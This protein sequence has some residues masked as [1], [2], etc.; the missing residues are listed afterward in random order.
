[1]YG[2]L[3]IFCCLFSLS[4]GAQN[5]YKS[6]VKGVHGDSINKVDMNDRKQGKWVER[7]PALR[8]NPGY[9]AEGYYLDDLKVGTW[10]TYNLMGDKI[11]EE[12]FRY[13]NK[14]GRCRYFT[15]AGLVRE[16]NW[17][18]PRKLDKQQLDTILVQ[19]PGEPNVY[20]RVV[21][22]MEGQSLKHGTW[23]YFDPVYGR[24]IAE[25]TYVLDVLQEGTGSPAARRDTAVKKQVMPK[26][27]DAP[28]HCGK[29]RSKSVIQ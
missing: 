10:K 13:G 9:E 17:R 3:I 5:Q 1:M 4:A 23:R 2:R 21:I 26:L 15:V 27:P 24:I 6:F 7:Y 14:D 11:A 8:G 20:K 29:S 28:R 16:E 25:E 19:D 22:K 18:A 12:T